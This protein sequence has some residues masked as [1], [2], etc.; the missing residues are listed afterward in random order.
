MEYE[1]N[2]H[3]TSI[4]QGSILGPILFLLYTADVIKIAGRHG[5]DVHSYA[6]DS[7]L[8]LHTRAEKSVEQSAQLAACIADID[9]WRT[10]NC[11]KL[12]ADKAQFIYQ[13][14]Q[15]M[16]ICGG[17]CPL[18]LPFSLLPKLPATCCA[19]RRPQKSG[20]GVFRN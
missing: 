1:L 15:F 19:S 13:G 11:L 3:S 7:Q 8:Y 6:D 4:P 17:A 20:G 10:S 5:L 2:H 9:T 14:R 12:N 18:P 16:P